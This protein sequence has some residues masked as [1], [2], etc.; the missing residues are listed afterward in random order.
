MFR[1]EKIEE[2]G[3]AVLEIAGLE[4]DTFPDPWSE[5]SL[6]GT[7]K[8]PQAVIFGAWADDRL[9]G[10]VILYYAA[11]E[12]EIARIAVRASFRRRGAAREML[13]K[14]EDFCREAG[15]NRFLLDVRESNGPAIA[16]YEGYGFK[17]DGIRKKF[18]VN[19]TEDAILMSYK[20]V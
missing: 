4:Q 9:A 8:Q 3:E 18:Y 17:K 13:L 2:A 15:V 10:Y 5:N 7:L 19:P 1:I 11:D 16:F 6:K 14:L 12:G 20:I